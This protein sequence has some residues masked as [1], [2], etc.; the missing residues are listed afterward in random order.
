MINDLN[1]L[2]S[3]VINYKKTNIE[4]KNQIQQLNSKIEM[5]TNRNKKDILNKEEKIKEKCYI[6]KR[7]SSF[8]GK[9]SKEKEKEKLFF[10]KR[11]NKTTTYI[12]ISFIIRS[13]T[14]ITYT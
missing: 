2:K 9:T 4:L 6:K 8:K 11:I 7:I 12:I 13:I 10:E 1:S 14:N 5:L 3:T